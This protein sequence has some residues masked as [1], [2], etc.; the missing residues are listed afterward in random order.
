M[1]CRNLRSIIMRLLL[2]LFHGP[3]NLDAQLLI[4]NTLKR[5]HSRVFCPPST[6]QLHLRHFHSQRNGL[7]EDI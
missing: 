4:H 2:P 5:S 1:V 7:F 6:A 3:R